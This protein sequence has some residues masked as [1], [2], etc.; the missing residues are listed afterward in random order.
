MWQYNYTPNPEDLM[1]YGVLGMKWGVHHG[2]KSFGTNDE[3]GNIY[4]DRQKERIKKQA[5]RIL[6]RNIKNYDKAFRL[7][8]EHSKLAY[9]KADK[10]V[11][12][13]EALK[14]KGDQKGFEKYQSK[15]WK[16]LANHITYEQTAEQFA[17]ASSVS[18]KKL[19]EITNDI[20]KAG[21]D[22]VTNK[23]ISLLPVLGGVLISTIK[24]VDYKGGDH[25]GL[26]R[27]M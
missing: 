12:K 21:Q 14:N 25:D 17:N 15:A 18:K 10:F 2:R 24:S 23:S 22:Y 4:T 5:K 9:K 3:P 16:S 26:Q 11:L 7:Y 6:N 19:N 1:H 20:I 27:K 13:S 8:D